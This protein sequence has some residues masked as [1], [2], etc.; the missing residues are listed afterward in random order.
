MKSLA[1]LGVLLGVLS[2]S[3]NQ[4]PSGLAKDSGR[5]APFDAG[6]FVDVGPP[7]GTMP[8]PA[9][10]LTQ[11]LHPSRDGMYTDALMTEERAERMHLDPMFYAVFD[12]ITFAEMLYVD[13][14]RPTVDALFVA[15]S[16]NHLTAIDATT[17]QPIW[18]KVFGP[19]VIG[20]SI[21]CPQPP[22]VPNYG[23]QATP[24]ID[25]STRTIYV[26]S[27]QPTG[28]TPAQATLIY[29]ISIDDG[30][31]RPGWPVDVGRAVSGFDP[32]AHH[33]R[34]GLA[35]F[36]GT[37]YAA[38]SSLYDSCPNYHGW[39]IGI[40]TKA[41]THVSAWSTAA[42][43]GGIWG[44]IASDGASLFVSTGNTALGL[45]KWG[46]GEAVIRLT[47]SLTF[48]GAS[49]DY[50]APSNWQTLD[51]NDLD[52]GSASPMVF[53]L[54]GA[55]PSSLV[56]AIGKE[57]VLF[58]LDRQNLGGIGVS[59]DNQGEGLFSRKI[60]QGGDGVHGHGATYETAKGRY[61]V[62]RTN[63]TG[64][65]CPD[66]SQGDL[67]A[68]RVVPTSPP[69]FSVAWCATSH[70]YGSPVVTTT[71]G[72]SNPIVWVPAP[73]LTNRLYG[74]D[75]DTGKVVYGGGGA[76]DVMSTMW[77]WVSPVVAKGRLYVAGKGR[78]YK[79]APN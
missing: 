5:D 71:D 10:V 73:P 23:I 40:S 42:N 18:D 67:I 77:R 36:G 14:F 74:F 55:T 39:V 25:P 79:F 63:G 21:A 8:G 76:G 28:G 51:E 3:G 50:F 27:F 35:L 78:V 54:P 38:F 52:L 41:P 13:G 12:G 1:T 32:T 44:G 26:E 75:G 19:N 43:R 31:V 11:H 24:V 34:A 7:T 64:A 37:V 6:P 49:S 48:S 57:G 58:L 61:V 46:G 30:S 29:A 17:G 68:A 33:V 59:R 4:S 66:G 16:T 45:S 20:S 65:G 9:S 15:T 62:V 47:T 56:A 60:A 69:T 70:G 53:D 22:T 72:L 2:C